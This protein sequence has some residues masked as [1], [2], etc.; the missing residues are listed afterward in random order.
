MGRPDSA[1]A[2]LRRLLQ[3]RLTDV[4]ASLSAAK[5]LIDNAVYDTTG[6]QGD[7]VM[8]Q[9][10]RAAFA[11]GIE[12]ARPFL[13][14]GLASADTVVWINSAVLM[15][16]AGS[17][18]AQAQAYDRAYVWLDT[19]L[20]LVAPRSPADTVGP[21]QQIRVNASFWF[22]ISSV[23][24]AAGP[25]SR[26]AQSK[27]CSEAKA[28]NDRLKRTRAA[29]ELGRRVHEQ[30]VSQMLRYLGQYENAMGSVKQSFKCRNF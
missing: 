13:A 25:Y 24:T 30:T 12:R 8:L 29:L 22:G 17:K 1:V 27:S 23:V 6:T 9:Q 16:S 28:F 10:R 26:L 20:T 7:S 4:A 18:L 14:T 3:L 5:I 21:R 11:D 2:L 19:L 15:L